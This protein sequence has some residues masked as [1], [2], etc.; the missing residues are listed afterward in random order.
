MN[1]TWIQPTPTVKR[2]T[3]E[4][5]HLQASVREFGT[6]YRVA[7]LRTADGV[8]FRSVKVR[9]P[10]HDT[11]LRIAADHLIDVA[12]EQGAWA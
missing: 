11:A 4:H 5:A 8:V 12:R 9:T 7:V 6:H 1:L 10:D 2:W 3:A